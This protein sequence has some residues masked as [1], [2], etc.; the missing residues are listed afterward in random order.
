MI[1][2]PPRDLTTRPITDRVKESLFAII[3]PLL[4]GA[5]VADLFCGTGSLGLEAL[6]RGAT[7]AIMVEQNEDALK[8]LRKNIKKLD[9]EEQTSVIRADVFRRGIPNLPVSDTEPQETP[10]CNLVF[11]DPPYRLSRTAGPDT[12]LGKLLAK[13][14][15]QIAD[16]GVVVVRHQRRTE[17]RRNYQDL[18]FQDRREYG[19]M[20]I[21]FF[22]KISP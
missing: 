21:T 20:A 4:A 10:T 18:H 2:L 9:F 15:D 22:E 5:L 8:R 17:L 3:Q 6:S 11:I 7:H 16:R 12:P 19:S 13:V 14:S 1:L